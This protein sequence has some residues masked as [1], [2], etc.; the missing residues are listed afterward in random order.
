MFSII[1]VSGLNLVTCLDWTP[2]FD[3]CGNRCGSKNRHEIDV[4]YVEEI[5]LCAQS[6]LNNL[7]SIFNIITGETYTIIQVSSE[8]L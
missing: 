7:G 6:L 1:F 4:M 2:I 8:D 3:W 5:G